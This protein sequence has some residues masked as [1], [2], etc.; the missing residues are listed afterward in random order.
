MPVFTQSLGD[1]GQ[2]RDPAG[3][4]NCAVADAIRRIFGRTDTQMIPMSHEQQGTIAFFPSRNFADHIGAVEAIDISAHRKIRIY[5][6]RFTCVI[7][8]FC[9]GAQLVPIKT[10]GGHQSDREFRT[11]R[12]FQCCPF[13]ATFEADGT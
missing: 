1:F 12:T 4:I 11:D 3:I 6:K 10:C 13:L 8:I 9:I 5:T 2:N 7:R